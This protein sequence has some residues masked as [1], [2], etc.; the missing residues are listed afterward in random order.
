M[1]ADF[2]N[3]NT[4]LK[5]LTFNNDKFCVSQKKLM[6]SGDIELNP[7]PL[8]S[9]PVHNVLENRLQQLGLKPLDVGGEGD[10]FFKTISHQLYGDCNHHLDVRNAG[11]KYMSEI[12]SDF[13]KA[14]LSLLGWIILQTCPHQAHGVII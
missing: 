8:N 4:I 13:L 3:N 14:I 2:L 5:Y 12:Q 1:R 11:V 10:C 6:L 7:G 9:I